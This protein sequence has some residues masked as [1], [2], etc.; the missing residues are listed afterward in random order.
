[1][2]RILWASDHPLATSGY[3]NQTRITVPRLQ[4]AGVAQLAVLATYG[5]HGYQSIWEDVPVYPGGADPFANDVIPI[6]AK[7]WQADA[8]IT[9]K[10][11]PVF[12][13]QRIQSVRWLPMTPIDHE[14]V[15]P[16]VLERM[17][18]AYRPI[19][20]APNGVR[21]LRAI[22]MDP[23]YAP[24]GYDP[25]EFYPGDRLAAR[26]A[27]NLPADAFIVGTVAVNRGGTPSRK[28]WP[29]LIA[30]MGMARR[31]CPN[32][33]WLAHTY[34]GDDG[35]EASLPLR[36]FAHEA[37]LSDC[38][39][40]PDPDTYKAG[41][42]VD[43]LRT[44]YQAMDVLLCVSLGEGFGIP[45]LEAQAC[46]VPVILGKWAAQEDLLFAGWGLERHT[47]AT[48][49]LD[50][51]M[52]YVHVPHPEAI[53]ELIRTAYAADREPL[54]QQALDGA[55][56]YQID[57]LIETHWRPAF[58]ELE[59]QI[60]ADSTHARGVVRIVMPGEVLE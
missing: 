47:D 36:K 45:T 30:G 21:A 32:L 56:A 28:A 55:A 15:P 29:E 11:T 12:D 3:S 23:L 58:A 41:Y 14:P 52:S 51:Q 4:R 20:Y 54:R 10:D 53:A 43:H 8:V 35:F 25:A 59:A 26:A 49:I 7:N 22:G 57:R 13:P 9:L 46:G 24:H 33:L 18:Y 34:A 60:R 5:Q 44:M 50:Q 16:A 17:R 2:L 27:L 6:A 19:A 1:M 31:D 39:L 48:A 40:L 38:F 42:S 37:G